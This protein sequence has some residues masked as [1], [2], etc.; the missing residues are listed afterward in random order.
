MLVEYGCGR[1][2]G[3]HMRHEPARPPVRLPAGGWWTTPSPTSPTASAR[4]ASWR[5]T[6]ACTRASP[7]TPASSTAAGRSTP[8]LRSASAALWW[9]AQRPP[10]A[11]LAEQGAAGSAPACTCCGGSRRRRV[12]AAHCCGRAAPILPQEQEHQE[13]VRRAEY[14]RL[15][16]SQAPAAKAEG[17]VG[18]S[19]DPDSV[20][21]VP[22]GGDE[23]RREGPCAEKVL[24]MTRSADPARYAAPWQGWGSS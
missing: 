19:G 14:A 12:P 9:G 8:G 24:A 21:R 13:S 2:Q 6:S 23:R 3:R 22:G 5:C 11:V 20:S 17:I 15:Y 10:L 4:S 1:H 16:E 18:S 7:S